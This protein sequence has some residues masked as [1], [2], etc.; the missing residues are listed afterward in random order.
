VWKKKDRGGPIVRFEAAEADVLRR[1]AAEMRALLQNDVADEP[2][3]ERLFPRAY[4]DD[5][6]QRA[7]SELVGGDLLGAKLGALQRISDDLE[8]SGGATVELTEDAVEPWLTALTDMRLAIG[9]RLEVTEE[10]MDRAPMDEEAEAPALSVLHWL[11]WV[12]QNMLEQLQ[13]R[14]ASG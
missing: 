1:L 5:A 10:T 2:V 11:G 12:Q 13:A 4:E 14:G 8:G 9:T 3:L 6:D 7:Y